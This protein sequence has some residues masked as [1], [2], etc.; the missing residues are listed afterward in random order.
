MVQENQSGELGLGRL[1]RHTQCFSEDGRITS[2]RFR[3]GVS[4]EV[5]RSEALQKDMNHLYQD[6]FCY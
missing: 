4:G 3:V 2:Q 1:G 5:A 6:L